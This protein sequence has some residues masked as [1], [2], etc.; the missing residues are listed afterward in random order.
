MNEKLVC[1]VGTN[2][3]GKSS[4][5]I[6]LAKLY[7]GEIVSA[8]SRQVFK[9]LDLGTGK[10]TENEMQGVPHYLLDVANINQYYSLA[11][12]QKQAYQYIDSILLRGKIPFLVGGTGL[13]INAVVDGYNLTEAVPDMHFREQLEKKTNDELVEI[14][15]TQDTTILERID[16]QNRRRLIRAIEKIHSGVPLNLPSEPKYETLLIGVTWEKNI[17]AERIDERLQ[18]RIDNGMIEEVKNLINQGA[19]DDFLYRLGLEYRY[20]LYYLQGK[21]DSLEEFKQEL[22]KAIKKYAKRQMTWFRKRKDINWIDMENNSLE[23]A[24]KLINEFYNT[25][26]GSDPMRYE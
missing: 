12:F 11:D 13:Y 16:I 1:I 2:A 19:T 10:V 18:K 7:G 26:K 22:S 14:I 3:S 8:D 21:Y 9:G 15:R 5:A 6:E 24:S 25:A 17:L 23:Q 4:L 20:I